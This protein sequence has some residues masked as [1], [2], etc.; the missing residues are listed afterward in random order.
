MPP[1]TSRGGT[2]RVN[3]NYG[4]LSTEL[5]NAVWKDLESGRFD[6]ED[7]NVS[8]L[9]A[10]SRPELYGAKGGATYRSAKDKVRSLLKWKKEDPEEYW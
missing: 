5:K 9:V 3:T 7:S 4:T 8:S 2:R 10:S 1:K 6:Q